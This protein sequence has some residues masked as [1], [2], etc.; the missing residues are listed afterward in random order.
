MNTTNEHIVD[1][2]LSALPDYASYLLKDRLNDFVK[3]LYQISLGLNIPLLKYF[4]GMHE[5]EIIRLSTDG[6]IRLLTA[7]KNNTIS[8]YIEESKD[9][10]LRNQLPIITKTD[11]IADD[12]GLIN[13]ARKKAFR[14]LLPDYTSNA[15]ERL[16]IIDEIDRFTLTLESSLYKTYLSIQQEKLQ[17]TNSQLKKREDELLE[18]QDLGKIGSFEWDLTGNNKSSYTPEVF[19]IFEFE[20]TSDLETFLNDVHPDD[21]LKLKGAMEKAFHD[22]SYECEYRYSRNN[23]DKVLYSR[24]RVIFDKDKPIKMVGTIA[25]IS[26]KANLIARLTENEELSKQAQALTNTGNWKWNIDSDTIEWSDEMYRIYGLEPQS[27]KITFHRF[28][29]FIHDDDRN[30]R[31]AEISDAIKTGIAADYIMRINSQ[32]GIPK[33]LK[34]K[35]RVLLD[36]FGKAIGMHG[37]CQDITNEH[38]LTSELKNT[39]EELLR[40]NKDLESFNFIAS[41]NLQEPLRKI[42]TYSNR[43]LDGDVG[44]IP[45]Y[46]MKY[47]SKI[48]HASNRM[49]KIVE[50]F[51]IFYHALNSDDESETIDLN[52]VVDDASELL[53]EIIIAK[54]GILTV[55][56]LPNVKGRRLRMTEMF[57]HLLSNAIKF[58][59]IDTRPEIKVSSKLFSSNEDKKYVVVSITDNGIGFDQ[60][61][62]DR[63]FE[64]FQKLHSQD[65]YSGS[66]IGLS[67]CKKIAED[68]GG[69]ISVVSQPQ[70]GSTFNVFIPALDQ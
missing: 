22:G 31:L 37:T 41:H 13:Y 63:I 50:D 62:S 6:N 10:W 56:T 14:E 61:Y 66:G 43:I 21:R 11:V 45:E 8:E 46:L 36:K 65:E 49:Q 9:N 39:N 18:A 7:I 17:G 26:E 24:G 64:L 59:K 2:H 29:S 28:L 55:D 69:W 38:K 67:L 15:H 52:A 32:E 47:L 60:R 20:Q 53:T 30:K 57:R 34:G 42:Q 44:S 1:L 51:L 16:K 27:E 58:A 70:M 4:A 23:N 68:H 19:K 3:N 5:Q 48:S 12:I 25:D 54:K 33:V 35:G 40:K